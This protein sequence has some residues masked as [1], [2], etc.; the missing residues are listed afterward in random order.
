MFKELSDTTTAIIDLI[1]TLPE[2]EQR[3]IAKTLSAPNRKRNFGRKESKA[4]KAT[5][6]FSWEGGLKKLKGK[7]DG[8]NLQH[9]INTLR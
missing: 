2:R 7:F 9:H 4:K 8:V 3:A 1:R 5:L 6:N